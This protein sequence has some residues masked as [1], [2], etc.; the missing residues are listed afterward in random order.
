MLIRDITNKRLK[1]INYDY[2]SLN[3]ILY[4]PLYLCILILNYPVSYI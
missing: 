2:S 4:T 3:K 1:I